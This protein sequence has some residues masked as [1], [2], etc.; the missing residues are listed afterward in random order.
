MAK[1]D[2]IAGLEPG[3]SFVAAG[4]LI[5]H[6]RFETMWA[7]RAGTL[8]GDEESLHDMRVGSR[9]LAAKKRQRGPHQCAQ[10]A[11]GCGCLLNPHGQPTPSRSTG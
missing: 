6:S 9:R 2:E 7:H 8:E 10:P 4:R 1:E 3:Q 11:H 5:I